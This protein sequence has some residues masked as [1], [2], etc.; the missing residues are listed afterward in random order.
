MFRKRKHVYR[1]YPRRGVSILGQKVQISCQGFGVAGDVDD[2][3]G[4]EGEEGA[5]ELL[6]AAGAGRVGED[7]IGGFSVRREVLHERACVGAEDA[8]VVGVIAPRVF[9]GVFDRVGVLLD[10][11]HT[12]C[13]A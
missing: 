7:D 4:G 1:L 8:H 6:R 9:D 3:F 13:L 2:L 12:L 11:Q 10:G 5:E